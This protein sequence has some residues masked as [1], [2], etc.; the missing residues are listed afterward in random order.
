MVRAPLTTTHKPTTHQ[1]TTTNNP[2]IV[3]FG[4]GTYGAE[5]ID[6]CFWVLRGSVFLD[7]EVLCVFWG[8]GGVWAVE[9]W[10]VVSVRATKS[11]MA[12]RL[13]SLSV[14]AAFPTTLSDMDPNVLRNPAWTYSD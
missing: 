2:V 12:V 5:D 10:L 8:C 1:H 11:P 14:S 13:G 7:V 3:F 9:L 6:W 4:G